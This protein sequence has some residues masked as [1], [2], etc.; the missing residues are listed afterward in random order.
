MNNYSEQPV[1]IEALGVS[2]TGFGADTATWNNQPA[3]DGSYIG[4]GTVGCTGGKQYRK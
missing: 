4:H 1:I 3:T 2:D